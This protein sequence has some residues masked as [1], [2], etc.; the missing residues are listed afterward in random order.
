M[1]ESCDGEEGEEKGEKKKRKQGRERTE[2]QRTGDHSI[3]QDK[4]NPQGCAKKSCKCGSLLV[5]SALCAYAPLVWSGLT[6]I[7][8]GEKGSTQPLLPSPPSIT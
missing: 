1:R 2:R 4:K 6:T 3:E 8:S 5:L 7:R